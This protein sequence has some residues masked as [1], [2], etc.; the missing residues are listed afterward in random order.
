MKGIL[1]GLLVAQYLDSALL[2]ILPQ[3]YREKI[4]SEADEIPF[5]DVLEVLFL[6]VYNPSR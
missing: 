4:R 3:P 2:S 5:R 1:W 6:S